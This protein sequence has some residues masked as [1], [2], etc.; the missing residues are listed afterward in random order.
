MHAPALI[1]MPPAT[2]GDVSAPSA[3]EP[4]AIPPATPVIESA[5]PGEVPRAEAAAELPVESGVEATAIGQEDRWSLRQFL[6]RLNRL[7]H[8]N[9]DPL[10]P[11][12]TYR[13]R[14]RSRQN[15]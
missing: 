4:R 2:R 13:L 1:E 15:L 8:S 12:L 11:P 9:R 6:R 10:R 14:R 7:R 3:E 5:V